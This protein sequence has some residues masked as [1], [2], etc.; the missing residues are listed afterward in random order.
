MDSKNKNI[1]SGTQDQV[2]AAFSN[3][4]II[5][6]QL[7]DKLENTK[8]ELASKQ[9]DV[10]TNT[11]QL[12]DLKSELSS[13]INTCEDIYGVYDVQRIQLLE[14]E[15]NRKNESMTTTWKRQLLAAGQRQHHQKQYLLNKLPPNRTHTRVTLS[16]VLFMSSSVETPMKSH[17]NLV[18][19]LWCH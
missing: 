3:K 9:A 16:T 12:S 8:D 4:Q 11:E 6:N 10:N 5:I 1:D 2:N 7:K 19:L 13:L 18:I 14:L 15:N 17:S